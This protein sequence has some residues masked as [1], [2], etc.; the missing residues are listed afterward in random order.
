M[1][2][3]STLVLSLLFVFLLGS[4]SL[5][6]QTS[7]VGSIRGSA[8]DEQGGRVAGAQVTVTNTETGFSRVQTT[9]ASGNYVFESLPIGTYTL[10]ASGQGFKAFDVRDIV[11][12]VNDNLTLNA[13]LKVGAVTET[14]EVAANTNQVELA[15]AELSSTIAGEQVTQLPLNGRSFAQLLTL[16]PGVA[17]ANGFSYDKKG[18]AGGA[19]LS[20]SG[21]ASNANLFLVDGANN[22]DVGSNRTILIYPSLDSIGEFKVERN[23][24]NAEFGGAGGGIVTLVTKSGTNDF[25]G[26]AYYF[27]RNDLLDAKDPILNATN[28]TAKKNTIRRNDFGFSIGGPIIKDKA[29]FFVSEEWNRLITDVVKT[30]HVPTPGERKG[31]FSDAAVDS[32][33]TTANT[34]GCLQ[35]GGLVDPD[36][37]NPGGAFTA[38][39]ST[40]GII[41]VIPGGRQSPAGQAILNTYFLPTLAAG[42]PHYGCGNNWAQALKQPTFYRED[43]VRGDVNLSRTLTLMMKYTGDSWDFGPSAVGNTGWGADSGASQIQDKWSQPGKVVVG[44]LS[45]VISNTAVNDFQFSWSANR[46]NI[47]QANQSSAAALNKVIPTFFNAGSASSPPVWVTGGGLPTIWSFAPWTNRED[48]YTWQDDFSKVL[49]KHTLRFGAAIST[50]AKDQDNFSQIQGQASG[51]IGYN[52]C[53]NTTGAGCTNLVDFTTH[54]GPADY[55]LKNMGIGWSEQNQ[56]FKKQ[57]RWQNYEFYANDDFKFSD[58]LTFNLGVRYSYLPNPYQANDQLTVFNPSAFNPALGNAPCNGLLYSSGLSAN[59]CPAGTGGVR[60]PNRAIQDNFH[61]GF[62]PRLGVAWDPTG[63]HRTSIRAG[64]GQFYNRDDIYVTDGTAGVNPPFISSFSSPKGNGRFLDNTNQLPAC[65]PNCFSTGLGTGS[66]GQET[67]NR[68]PYAY[69]YN[70]TV[71]HE[72]WR[73]TRLEVGYV[74]SKARD[75]TS[76]YDANAVPLAGRL[77]FAQSNATANALQPFNALTSGTITLFAHHGASRY[78]SLQTS[79]VSRPNRNSIVQVAYTWSKSYSDTY[80]AISNGGNNLIVDPYNTRAQYGQS[81]INRPQ[82]FSANFVY[83]LPTLQG[84][85]RVLRAVFGSWETGSIISLTSGSSI[86]PVIGGLANVNDPSG[87]GGNNGKER[88][89]LVPGQPCKNPNFDKNGD[90]NWVNPNRYTMNGF[91]LGTIGNAPVGDCLGPPTRTVDFSLSKN[92]RITERIHAQFR[93]DAFNLFNHPN[94]NNPGD[95]T[96]GTVGIGFNAVNTAASPEFLTANGTPT[97]SLANAVRI[98]NSSPSARPGVVST[99]S[100]RSRE[101]QYSLRFT[102]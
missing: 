48:L 2:R 72:L 81:Q 86:T 52:G 96:S 101:F 85:E 17:V 30:A 87:I 71:Q 24:Y 1:K 49:S 95:G 62:A 80:P 79:L 56:I 41:D 60:G 26:S 3:M 53:K 40:P 66:I 23:S 42:S 46:I 70:L 44:K 31:D 98:Q 82:I 88:P 50:N 92:I 16:V 4:P 7:G 61:W 93:M 37:T 89:N 64:F 38:S 59:P 13:Q 63:R 54:Y 84:S 69:Q 39:S 11:L 6:P 67:S 76:K 33:F 12:H 99:Q 73:D 29:F 90:F 15:T 20:V 5:L 19:D 35:K 10:H 55:L 91:T 57:G 97:T 68:A 58:R 75:W 22:V 18:L 28:P 51:P 77:A 14:V 32:A 102:F 83:L 43:S 94:F 36:P 45:K 8:T 47:S 100:D 9:D 74:G 65:T 21:G 78:D 27:G 34:T 25:H